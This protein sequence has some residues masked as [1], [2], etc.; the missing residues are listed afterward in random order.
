MLVPLLVHKV[1][2]L[3]DLAAQEQHTILMEIQ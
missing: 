3:A 1:L 2:V